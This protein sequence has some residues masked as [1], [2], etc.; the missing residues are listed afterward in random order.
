MRRASVPERQEEP[1]RLEA[2][3]FSSLPL[4]VLKYPVKK[5]SN[6]T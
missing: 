3:L 4:H 1:E 6:I 5:R 2:T